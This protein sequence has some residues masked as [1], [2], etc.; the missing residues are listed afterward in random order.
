M[1][2]QNEVTERRKMTDVG[3]SG[4]ARLKRKDFVRERERDEKCKVEERA[5]A[6]SEG[7]V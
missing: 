5:V 4:R 2:E 1:K 6:K 3:G 7:G